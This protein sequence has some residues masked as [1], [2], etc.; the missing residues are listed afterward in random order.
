M[1]LTGRNASLAPA[2]SFENFEKLAEACVDF[3][4]KSLKRK[5]FSDVYERRNQLA[6]YIRKFHGDSGTLTPRVE[7]AIK[8]LEGGSCLLLMTA[9]QPNLFAYSGVLRKAT[10][11]HVLAKRLSESLN[12][13]V[14]SFF[15]VADQD[16]TDDRWVRSALL[17]DVQ[18]RD[19]LLDLR[20][21]MPEKLMLNR[22]AKPSQTILDKWRDEIENWIDKKLSSIGRALRSF[23]LQSSTEN[24][25]LA[26]NFEGF[27]KLVKE[28][29]E[30]A[31]TYADFNAFVMSRIV[32]E[33]WEYGTVFSK[34]S[35]CQQ[36]FEREFCFLLSRF[37]EYSRYVKE[38]TVQ[39]DYLKRGVHGPE[40][41]TVPFWYHCDCGSKARLKAEQK[42]DSLIGQGRC[43]RCG[44]EYQLD[45]GSKSEPQISEIVKRISAR[46]L[47]MPLVFFNGLKVS[48][49]VGGIG[50]TEYL[51][52][53]QYVG[54]R[55]GMTFAPVVVWR[56]KDVY[57]GVGQLEAL[58]TFRKLSGTFD[59][60]QYPRIEAV[61][62]KKVAEVQTKLD[63][64]ETQK[65]Q[66]CAS[67]AERKDEQV[68]NLRVL[69]A[70]Q[71]EVRR[72]ADFSVLVRNLRLLE[73]V[74]TVMN[75]YPCIV[76]YAVN[77]GL[78]ETSEQWI[79][80]L[81]RNGSL[82]SN[83]CLKTGFDNVEACAQS[84]FGGRIRL[85]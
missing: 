47:S 57:F 33:V 82:A 27:W 3:Y 84:G 18:R 70:R 83:V 80:F 75:L 78:R 54:K 42:G 72:Q 11:N 4:N 85:D 39:V 7:E 79:A 38:A 41:E 21:N 19:G 32:N 35:E 8:N 20:F 49:Y 44:K 67:S 50:G 26:G 28:A 52:Q 9:H 59:F 53:A 23:G 55:L 40:A 61:L 36:I 34:F 16:F 17:P 62:K 64:L 2:F 12:V 48:C 71:V 81:Q 51:K 73:N 29:Y 76:D 60:S 56:P 22:V 37:D 43:V 45:F 31:E 30:Q 74:A 46:S 6:K 13:P 77:V 66:L 10:L 15:G 63:E 25:D 14:V 68:Q 24:A 65:E 69:S 1:S 58:M 5:D